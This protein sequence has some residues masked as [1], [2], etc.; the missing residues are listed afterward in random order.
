[1]TRLFIILFIDV[2][3]FFWG[4]ILPCILDEAFATNAIVQAVFNGF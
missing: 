3:G 4:T 2:G 1:M